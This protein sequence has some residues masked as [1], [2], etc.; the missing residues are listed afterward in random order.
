MI[1]IWSK[2]QCVFCDKAVNLCKIKDLEFKKYMLNE[3]FTME[4]LLDKFPHAKTFPQITQ[5]G[6]YVGGY[7]ELE[8]LL[9]K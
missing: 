1:E 9:K 3:D 4:D 5:H 8:I 6:N 7:T 2:P